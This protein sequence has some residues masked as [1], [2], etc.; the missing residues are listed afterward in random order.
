MQMESTFGLQ[1][2][3]AGV[4]G[5]SLLR[6]GRT[7][8]GL[9]HWG[10]VIPMVR[11]MP[12]RPPHPLLIA[13]GA[14]LLLLASTLVGIYLGVRNLPSG[15]WVAGT[16]TAD[17]CRACH[18]MTDPEGDPHA[19]LLCSAC[20]L[21]DATATAAV[22]AHRGMVRI[23]GNWADAAKTCGVC[24]AQE[25]SDVHHSLM[26]TNAGLVSVDR[27]VFGET[28]RPTGTTPITEIGH[29]PADDHLRNLCAACHLGNAKEA[30]GPID[31][32]SRGGGCN[33][34][35]L[36]YATTAQAELRAYLTDAETLPIAHPTL[37]LNISDTHCLG[38]HSR[39]GRI[40]M[41]YE[42][43]HETQLTTI[44]VG[45]PTRFIELQD[46]RIFEYVADDVHHEQG[47]SCIDCHAYVDVM[48]DGQVHEHEE[49]AVKIRCEDCHAD[50][51]SK[52]V[53]V[54]ESSEIDQRIH[55]SRGYTHE[56]VLSTG[57]GA[58]PLVNT[59]LP[60]DGR[61]FLFGKQDRA[62]HE[63]GPPAEVCTRDHGHHNLSC[64]ACHTRWA[65]QCM[66]CHTR[67]EENE[68]GWDLLE[69]KERMGAWIEEAGEFRAEAPA[70]G[71]SEGGDAP[72]IRPAVPGMILD[73]DLSRFPHT[74]AGTEPRPFHRLFA[75][76][77]P[78]TTAK[79]G[80]DCR[81]CHNN[82][83]AL[84]YGRGELTFSITEEG[85]RWDFQPTYPVNG[86]D[87][88]AADAW[89]G[90]LQPRHGPVS[91]RTDF[92]P[93]SIAE[94]KRILTVGACL[95]CHDQASERMQ[96]TLREDFPSLLESLPEAC[97][98]PFR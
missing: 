90:F 63:L 56:H 81:S 85:G 94:Q 74:P 47:M 31:D 40:S 68:P 53:A 59:Y 37:D 57:T 93:F 23:P 97:K 67:Y 76:A 61:A 89:I 62:L 6:S 48:G 17:G 22:E 13:G 98:L 11:E 46:G 7:I 38:C 35:H 69:N 41:N 64:T 55:R 36:N 5:G 1:G 4:H 60:G 51:W 83:T 15:R 43:F 3:C 86:P 39:S 88:L 29:S 42:G 8:A 33:A 34:C 26:T 25:V 79:V 2:E 65:P 10:W 82:P 70:L 80:R 32:G 96:Q 52:T 20:H 54:A 19:A 27:F 58:V 78:H 95:E 45:D 14:F 28:P 50:E 9:P 30:F 16:I 84:G 66:Q 71:V 92:R 49:E 73:L 72:G 75:P 44:P 77:A 24:H 12:I 21:G 91:T 18:A 87:G